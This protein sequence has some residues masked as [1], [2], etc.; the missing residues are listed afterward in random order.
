MNSYGDPSSARGRANIPGPGP[1]HGQ[2]DPWA[3]APGAYRASASAGPDHGWSGGGQGSTGAAPA[4]RASVGSASAGRASVGRAN[5]P[6]PAAPAPDESLSAGERPS[7]RA[8]VGAAR[9]G[10]ASGSGRAAVAR[11]SVRPV[12]GAGP[13]AGGGA[14]G[15]PNGPG[16]RGPGG[17]GGG[18]R[19]GGKGD[20]AD[21]KKA[22]KRKRINLIIAAFAVLVMLLGS[23]VV[24]FTWFADTVKTPTDFGEPMATTI[25]YN[26]GQQLAKLGE[27]NRTIVPADKINPDVKH[28][29][30]AAEDKNFEQHGGIDMKGIARAAWNNFTGGTTQG[31]STITQQYARHVA[32]LSG[33]N[34]ARKLREAVLA[35][36]L[37]D[38]F[39]KDELLG[40]YLNAIY[41]GRGAHGVEAAARA[42]FGKSV[43]APPGRKDAITPEEAAV[44]AS[45]IKQPE[46]DANTGHKGYDPQINPEAAKERWEYTLNNMQEKGWIAPE[47]RAAARYPAPAPKGTLRAWDPKKDCAVGCGLNTPSGNVVNYVRAELE[48]NNITDWKEGGYRIKTTINQQAQKAAESAARRASK[49]SPMNGL[50]KHYMAALV[51]VDVKTG[52]VLAYYG[53]DNASGTDYAGLNTDN[54]KVYGGHSPGSTFKVY[55]LAAALRAGISVDSHWDA[56][57][58]KDPET[59]FEISNA[60]RTNLNCDNGGKWC[61]LDKATVESYNVPFYWIAKALGPDK[62]VEAARDAGIR[63]MW[64][65][66][67]ETIDLTKRKPAEV[68]PAKFDKQV[69]YGQYAVTVLDHANGMAT[70]ANRGTY[71]KAHFIEEVHKYNL[72]TGK[73]D[74]VYGPKADP[75]EVFPKAQMDDLN[76]VLKKIPGSTGDAL[77]AN[78]VSVG[79]TGTWELN[80]T[81]NG[82]AWM[83]GATPQ[84]AAAVWVGTTGNRRAIE[85]ADGSM[86]FGGGTPAAIWKKFMD[87]AHAAMKVPQEGFPEKKGT[88][89]P[90]PPQANGVP[91]KQEQ[92]KPDN[93]DCNNPLR[94]F[95]PPDGNQNPGGGNG[96]GNGNNPGPGNPGN[97]G[98]NPGGGGDPNNPGDTTNP[99]NGTAPPRQN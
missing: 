68:A 8:V 79:K 83:I 82:D 26:N 73:W 21:A 45:V 50:P 38:E 1:D 97:P 5:I 64:T 12:S 6:A 56:T 3:S 24:A 63:T 31:A 48:A 55:T 89:D 2:A 90:N 77:A 13:R 67:T 85:E 87:D 43:L 84:I 62:I 4:G 88:G 74:L 86:M 94:L 37:E 42:Y 10:G 81:Q 19:G 69:S 71:N 78:R 20:P 80:D 36:K 23:G 25:M 29:V 52:K 95:C 33:I 96:N 32:E 9:V 99:L 49:S 61:D 18:G 41:F 34:Y 44:L 39:S 17:G 40:F 54:G 92:P 66:K 98:G 14:G 51:A 75:Q 15:G 35:S 59:G 22:K 93:G 76:S 16:G 7:G 57:K 28:A 72:K 11:A 60:G 53:G 30:M 70:I 27:Q 65:D 47:T 58:T 91:P 46:P